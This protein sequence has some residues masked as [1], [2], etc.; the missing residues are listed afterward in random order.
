MG[1]GE[2]KSFPLKLK[3]LIFQFVSNGIQAS[4]VMKIKTRERIQKLF[5]YSSFLRLS[6]VFISVKISVWL[7]AIH[8]IIKRFN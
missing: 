3:L 7:I 8:H 5:L 2:T 4:T 1:P 6:A